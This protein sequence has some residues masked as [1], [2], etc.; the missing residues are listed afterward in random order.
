MPR[1][2]DGG[3]DHLGRFPG[4]KRA[5][6]SKAEELA[7]VCGVDVV[8]LCSGPGGG[9]GAEFWPSR[10]AAAETVRR[11][12]ALPPERRAEHTEDHAARF[13]RE[14][15]A[16]GEKLGRARKGGS[17]GALG[18]LD[19]SLEG[20]SVGALQELLASIDGALVAARGRVQQQQQPPP[21]QQQQQQRNGTAD[22]AGVVHA[23]ELPFPLPGKGA[24]K[25]ARRPQP[26]GEPEAGVEGRGLPPSKNPRSPPNAAPVDAGEVVAE[27]SVTVEDA[28]DEVRI[29]QP[30]PGRAAAAAGDAELMRD[31]VMERDAE[32]MR[33]P[34][35]AAPFNAGV[36]YISVG[37]LVMERDAY[38]FIRF[39]L[40][41]PPPCLGPEIPDSP[42]DGE[43]LKLWSWD[44]TIPPL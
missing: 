19:G 33:D 41:M 9:G 14:L 27:N 31:L 24:G 28:C 23:D 35:H 10:E 18:S 15:A 36:E 29:L 43:P 25:P 22:H 6:R 1:G 12:S 20:M 7:R 11:Y 30:P 32:L 13:A 37:R 26:R 16:E 40:G 34:F 42:D 5:L 21:P 38:D 3:G 39:D 8:V 2:G 4:R 17:S 44:N